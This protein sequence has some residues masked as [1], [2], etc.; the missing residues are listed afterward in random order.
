MVLYIVLSIIVSFMLYCV[1]HYTLSIS[2]LEGLMNDT[3]HFYPNRVAQF[4]IDIRN[5]PGN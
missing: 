5:N 1:K 4:F 3:L 2:T